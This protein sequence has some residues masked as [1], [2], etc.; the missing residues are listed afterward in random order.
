MSCRELSANMEHRLEGVFCTRFGG[1]DSLFMEF[2]MNIIFLGTFSL[3]W[4]CYVLHGIFLVYHG[5]LILLLS[6]HPEHHI[7]MLSDSTWVTTSL[8][9]CLQAF[10]VVCSLLYQS[11]INITGISIQLYTAGLVFIIQQLA[12]QKIIAQRHYLTAVHDIAQAWTSIG[13]ALYAVWQQTGITSSLWRTL[14]VVIYLTC[15]SAL[16]IASSTIMQFTAFNS[17]S[18]LSVQSAVAWTNDSIFASGS[19]SS[20][21]PV[22]PPNSLSANFKTTGLL[23][24]TVYDIINQTSPD[25]TSAVVNAT[26]LQASCG[27]LSN[28]SFSN[29]TESL[30]FSMYGLG[31]SNLSFQSKLLK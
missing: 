31:P 20:V 29:N 22:F 21:V 5:V 30:S 8:S 27:L 1:I 17:T 7:I 6:Y 13:A 9:V 25:F 15:V 19:S 18:T 26:S 10:Y 16:H 2:A 4:W 11:A 3:H 24:N 23:N 28:L 12:V 14:G